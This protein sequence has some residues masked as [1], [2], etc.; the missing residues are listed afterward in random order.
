M[1]ET[2]DLGCTEARAL[3]AGVLATATVAGQTRTYVPESDAWGVPQPY[4]G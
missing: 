4:P 1:H 3:L 2:L